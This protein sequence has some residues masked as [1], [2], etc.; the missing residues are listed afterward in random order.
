MGTSEPACGDV[1]DKQ[2]IDGQ[3]RADEERGI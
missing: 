1:V 2:T 3:A